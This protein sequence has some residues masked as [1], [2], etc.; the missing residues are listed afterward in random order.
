MALT[1]NAKYQRRNTLS[2]RLQYGTIKTGA[3]IYQDSI[4]MSDV[5]GKLLPAADSTT[6]RYVGLA[7]AEYLTG[8][9]TRIA[10]AEDCIEVLMPLRTSVTVGHRGAVM[11]AYDDAQATNLATRGPQIGTLVERVAANLGWVALRQAALANAS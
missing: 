3:K 10:E 2:T 11:Y 7:R 1:A 6:G 9:G 4:L 5:A 8:N